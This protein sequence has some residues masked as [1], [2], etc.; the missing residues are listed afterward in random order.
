MMKRILLIMVCFLGKAYHCQD[1]T[2]QNKPLL[3]YYDLV[4]KAENH[5][6][7]KSSDSAFVHYKLAFKK[8]KQPPAID[9]YNSM[10]VALKLN[11]QKFASGKF[12]SLQCLH[13]QFEDDFAKNMH[14]STKQTKCR[15][16]ID[17]NYR[18][19]L[20][21]LYVIDQKYR[22]LSKGN[23]AQYRNELTQTD[24]IVAVKLMQLISKKGFP[25]EYD[26][27]LSSANK[28]FMQ[29][30]YFIIHHQLAT[31][32]YSPQIVNFSNLLVKALNDGKITP[33]NAAYLIDLNNGTTNYELRLFSV[34]GIVKNNGTMTDSIRA[35]NKVDYYISKAIYPENQNQRIRKIIIEKNQ[36]RKK[37]GLSNLENMLEKSLFRRKNKAFVFPDASV[38]ISSFATDK[39]ITDYIQNMGLIKIQ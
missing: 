22:K 2:L 38:S 13:Y 36:N 34:Q 23:Y 7:K 19:E 15:N 18:S 1:Y 3:H 39:D 21:K 14:A 32:I 4:N 27:G 35:L 5:I 12:R 24:S 26:I 33:A 16:I 9:L 10:L 17:E 29:N 6:T 11:K 8:N 30:F 31:N 28:D 25:N 20:D 37:I